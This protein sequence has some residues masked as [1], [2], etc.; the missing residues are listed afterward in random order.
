MTSLKTALHTLHTGQ[1]LALPTET[2]WGIGVD[3][4]SDAAIQALYQLKERD[5]HKPLQI[6]VADLA[7]AERYADLSTDALTL[8]NYFCPGPL[9]II[10]PRKKNAPLSPQLNTQNQTVALRFP[11]HP[12][13]LE[14]LTL[15]D[16][17][18]ASTSANIS[19]QSTCTT[20]QDIDAIFGAKV[21]TRHLDN[22]HEAYPHTTQ[23]AS[24]IIDMTRHDGWHILREGDISE[25]AIADILR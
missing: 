25:K 11:K 1:I 21:F 19:G 3:A 24:T 5:S 18:I 23:T 7:M 17:A 10:V 16:R 14:L 8:I 22:L 6:M 15:F 2:V 12:F 4:Q 20:R 9:S 13:T